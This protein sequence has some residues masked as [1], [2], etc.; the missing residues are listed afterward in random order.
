M[1]GVGLVSSLAVVQ[2]ILAVIIATG[3]VGRF[4]EAAVSGYGIGARLDYL[5]ILVTFGL[6]SALLTIMGTSIGA[7]D[8][9]RARHIAIT[10]TLI[11]AAFTGFGGLIVAV[12]PRFWLGMLSQ[13]ESVLQ[14]GS[15]YLHSAGLSYPATA[16]AFNLSC[17]SQG[18]GRPGWTTFA[19]TV[20][21]VV[22]AGLGFLAVDGWGAGLLTL[23]AIVAA[24][25]FVAALI[26]VWAAYRRHIW[27]RVR[28]NEPTGLAAERKS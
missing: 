17:V 4:G 9:A 10:C 12:W 28:A 25:H 22:A 6:G 16:I 3:L 13:D 20:G 26:C 27:P 24:S 5:F 1:L 23:S 18:S 8:V 7:G 14:A 2:I 21:L 19:G 11:G 15:T